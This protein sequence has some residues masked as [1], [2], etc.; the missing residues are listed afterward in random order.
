[1]RPKGSLDE[2]GVLVVAAEDGSTPLSGDCAVEERA[3]N[4]TITGSNILKNENGD[5][6]EDEDMMFS[7]RL[8]YPRFGR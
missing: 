3:A 8:P 1:V 4:R 5:E 7:S 2:L 6:N